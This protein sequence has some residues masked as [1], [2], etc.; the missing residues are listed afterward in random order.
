MRDL[1][2]SEK[3]CMWWLQRTNNF[4]ISLK[5]CKVVNS[6]KLVIGFGTN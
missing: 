2:A 5:V 1:C 6:T 4:V 3:K